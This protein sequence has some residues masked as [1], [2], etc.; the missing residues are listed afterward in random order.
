[1]DA[2]ARVFERTDGD[3]RA[4]ALATATLDAA[5]APQWYDAV[6]RSTGFAGAEGPLPKIAESH[7]DLLN[8]ALPIYE[9]PHRRRLR[10]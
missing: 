9:A 1:M 7:Q 4:L 2:L 10:A 6:H 5:W 3:L 8:H